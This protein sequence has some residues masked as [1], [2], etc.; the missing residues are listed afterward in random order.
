MLSLPHLTDYN[1]G[2]PSHATSEKWGRKGKLIANCNQLGL[3]NRSIQE[4]P[5]PLY[6]HFAL[7]FFLAFV[8]LWKYLIHVLIDWLPIPPIGCE[9]LGKSDLFVSLTILPP[10]PG[11]RLLAGAWET[12]AEESLSWNLL[13]SAERG[14]ISHFPDCWLQD[15]RFALDPVE[16]LPEVVWTYF[17][18]VC[19]FP[20]RH[21]SCYFLPVRI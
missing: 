19:I 5:P 15:L 9:L 4:P 14:L 11:A 16:Q 20:R 6:F 2:R 8:V 18:H 17:I 10:S 1:L 7:I 12:A 21:T 3:I 13:F